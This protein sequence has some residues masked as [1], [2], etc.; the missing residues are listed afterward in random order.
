MYYLIVS[1]QNVVNHV[2]FVVI[3]N[4]A[5]SWLSPLGVKILSTYTYKIKNNIII[6]YVDVMI[7]N[8]IMTQIIQLYEC[9]NISIILPQVQYNNQN[10]FTWTK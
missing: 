4:H 2:K 6:Y 7:W 8:I 10:L 5:A 9:D 1:N 3:F